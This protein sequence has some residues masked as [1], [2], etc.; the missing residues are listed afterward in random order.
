M[1]F[2]T[3]KCYLPCPC[4]ICQYHLANPYRGTS[5]DWCTFCYSINLLV[6]SSGWHPRVTATVS[7][8]SYDFLIYTHATADHVINPRIAQVFLVSNHMTVQY[9]RLVSTGLFPSRLDNITTVFP[10]R[11]S[12]VRTLSCFTG[13]R[14][15]SKQYVPY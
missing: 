7:L 15:L 8:L 14:S 13:H 10:H 4:V 9:I 5:D 12:P 11:E 1:L 3:P 2:A 6:S